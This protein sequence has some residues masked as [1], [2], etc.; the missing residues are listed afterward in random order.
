MLF[1]VVMSLQSFFVGAVVAWAV[2]MLLLLMLVIVVCRL[3]CDV[4]I[5]L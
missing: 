5:R 3:L 4:V 1:I 2:V